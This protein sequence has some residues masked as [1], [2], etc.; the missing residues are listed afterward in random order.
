MDRVRKRIHLEEVREGR[1]SRYPITIAVLDSGIG[2]HPDLEGKCMAFK[3]FVNGYKEQPYDDSG[4]GT[5]VCGIICGS[6][7]ISKGRYRGMIP[8][9]RLVVGKV[10]DARGEG[11]AEVMIQ[12]LEWILE[13]Q[14]LHDIRLLNI[15]VGIGSLED[16]R[17]FRRLRELIEYLWDA[18]VVVIC[19]AGNKGPA[20]GSISDVGGTTKAIIVGCCDDFERNRQGEVCELHSGRGKKSDS[21]RKPDLVAPGTNIISCC[22]ECRWGG[23]GYKKPYAPLSGTSMATPIVTGAAALLLQSEPFL[24][25]DKIRERLHYT[26]EDLGKPWNLQGWGMV[27]VKRLIE[28]T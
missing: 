8:N 26:S 21:E 13:N 2:R 22:H 18:G 14:K 9:S 1:W 12:G 23:N 3:D 20:E 5:H 15:S 27:D 6:G 25:N 10:L 4:H 17:K 19:A 24:S 28:N 16:R 7:E 11:K